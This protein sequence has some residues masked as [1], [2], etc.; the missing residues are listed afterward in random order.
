MKHLIDWPNSVTMVYV[1]YRLEYERSIYPCSIIIRIKLLNF[2]H[3]IVSS[4]SLEV[5]VFIPICIANLILTQ[6]D[7]KSCKRIYFWFNPMKRFKDEIVEIVTHLS[8][9]A[10]IIHPKA[11][12]TDFNAKSNKIHKIH[13][14]NF[15]A[16]KIIRSIYL[17][18]LWL[19]DVSDFYPIIDGKRWNLSLF[20]INRLFAHSCWSIRTLISFQNWIEF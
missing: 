20:S 3:L 15:N 18:V 17:S 14:H 4:S 13:T 1:Y 12:I 7:F 10:I 2:M 16:Y 6:L 11:E 8:A 9:T 5:T 19:F